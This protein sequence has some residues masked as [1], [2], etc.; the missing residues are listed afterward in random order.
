MLKRLL[1]WVP[2]LNQLAPGDEPLPPTPKYAVAGEPI[3]H[4][5]RSTGRKTE[6][7]PRVVDNAE[8]PPGWEHYDQNRD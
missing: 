4:P 7:W 3:D 8:L 2:G 6:G 5:Q 1:K